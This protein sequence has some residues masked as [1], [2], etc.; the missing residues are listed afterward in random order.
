MA[1][2]PGAF[3]GVVVNQT[4]EQLEPTQGVFNFS[5]LDASLAVVTAYNSTHANAP[6]GVRLRVFTRPL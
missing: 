5:T 3:G 4:W 6:I 2:K 1:A